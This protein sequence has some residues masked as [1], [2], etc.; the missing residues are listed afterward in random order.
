MSTHTDPKTV[1]RTRMVDGTDHVK[2]VAKALKL[3]PGK[4]AFIKMQIL[5]EDGTV[6]PITGSPAQ[7]LA[8]T[9]AARKRCNEYSSW[10]WLAA[11]TG[12]NEGTLKK[13]VAATKKIQ[14]KGSRIAIERAA[15][16]AKK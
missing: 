5:V 10:G 15:K 6:A 16:R 13:N 8:K 4:T 1:V 12:M 2:D 9:I 11:R 7:V 3:T 14:V